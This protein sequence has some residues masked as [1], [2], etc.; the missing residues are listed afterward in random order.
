M[1]NFDYIVNRGSGLRLTVAGDESES[2]IILSPNNEG[3]AADS[4]QKWELIPFEIDSHSKNQTTT[5]QAP[6]KGKKLDFN[7]LSIIS[8]SK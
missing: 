2:L 3:N 4:Y 7:C 1:E 8:K 6:V 5:K